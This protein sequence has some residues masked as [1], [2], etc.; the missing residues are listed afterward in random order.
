MKYET[1]DRIRI[2][3]GNVY[4]DSLR[5]AVLPQ[6]FSIILRRQKLTTRTILTMISTIS[7]K[8]KALIW[9]MI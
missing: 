5:S 2:N 9:T 8:M 7:L 4:S 6:V 1:I 3:Y